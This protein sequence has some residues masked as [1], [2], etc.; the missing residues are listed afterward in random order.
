MPNLTMDRGLVKPALGAN[1]LPDHDLVIFRREGG[2]LRFHSLLGPS[3]RLSLFDKI[4]LGSNL[5]V[6]AVSRDQNLRHKLKIEGLKS[7]D[8]VGPFS[9][10]LT[11]ALR[12][13]DPQVL[14]EKLESDPV[15]RLEREVQEILGRAASR[16]DWTEVQAPACDFEDQLLSST[17]LD[18]AGRRVPGLTFL[19]HFAEELGLEIKGIQVARRFSDEVGEA[20]RVAWREREQRLIAEERQK[21]ALVNEQLR[22]RLDEYQAWKINALGNIQRLGTISA[23]ATAN[24]EKVLEQIAD[25]V[26]TAPA[27]RS[28]IN[29]LISMRNEIAT[30]SSMGDARDGNGAGREL[31]VVG[32]SA[33][34]ALLAADPAA[35]RLSGILN[36]LAAVPWEPADRNR[37]QA[38]LLRLAGELSLQGE[39]NEKKVV[40][41]F[42]A[43]EEQVPRLVKA[44]QTPEQ[45]DLLLQLQDRDWLRAELGQV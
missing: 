9:L 16:M 30:I 24:L 28:V 25:K 32:G 6:Y 39:A 31:K 2:G 15:L 18:D 26:D 29:E 19:Q 41:C 40:E 27:L 7:A 33:G 17:V 8:L 20:A 36:R 13:Q 23:S 43:L 38:G 45:R 34:P 4:S 11:L 22:T 10:D 12:A 3:D 5:A 42:V 14:V 35:G 37:L 21:T 1:P 44:V